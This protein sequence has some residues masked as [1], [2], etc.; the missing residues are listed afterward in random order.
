VKPSP[1]SG[2]LRSRGT[3]VPHWRLVVIAQAQSFIESQKCHGSVRTV[4]LNYN[5]KKKYT[6]FTMPQCIVKNCKNRTRSRPVLGQIK[7]KNI[8]NNLISPIRKIIFY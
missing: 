3:L 2:E 1:G 7:E 4:L 5:S 8:N 6:V